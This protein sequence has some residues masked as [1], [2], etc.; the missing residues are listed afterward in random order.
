M[1]GDLNLS[2]FSELGGARQ[3]D[4][5]TTLPRRELLRCAIFP[6]RL[7]REF[8]AVKANRGEIICLGDEPYQ[9]L[10]LDSPA[11]DP[12][13]DLSVVVEDIERRGR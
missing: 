12:G 8:A 3:G 9:D 10:S 13:L 6:H 1:I 7:Y 4:V 5:A 11:R 2:R